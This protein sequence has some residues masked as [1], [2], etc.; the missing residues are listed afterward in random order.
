MSALRYEKRKIDNKKN[1]N[2]IEKE[3]IGKK[4]RVTGYIPTTKQ[5]NNPLYNT[6]TGF[7]TNNKMYYLSLKEIIRVTDKDDLEVYKKAQSSIKDKK[8]EIDMGLMKVK[9]TNFKGLE[10]GGLRKTLGR[11]TLP[12]YVPDSIK[13]DY[14]KA[15]K[16]ADNI[17]Q[18]RIRNSRSKER[19]FSSDSS[20]FHNQNIERKNE[21]S[22]TKKHLDYKNDNTNAKSRTVQNTPNKSPNI[23]LNYRTSKFSKYN[24]KSNEEGGVDNKNNG[25]SN[26][27]DEDNLYKNSPNVGLR[28]REYN[29]NYFNK[30][31]ISDNKQKEEN[32]SIKELKE[33]N[34]KTTLNKEKKE[35]NFQTDKPKKGDEKI[36]ENEIKVRKRERFQIKKEESPK[37]IAD[38]GKKEKQ[39]RPRSFFREGRTFQ[40]SQTA[41][42]FPTKIIQGVKNEIKNKTLQ[43]N[44]NEKSNERRKKFAQ[45][46]KEEKIEFQTINEQNIKSRNALK[47][48]KKENSDV[49]NINGSR[50]YH[51]NIISQLPNNKQQNK[52]IDK[53]IDN[54]LNND[55]TLEEIKVN[56]RVSNIRERIK[57]NFNNLKM[58]S[59]LKNIIFNNPE[60]KY[61]VLSKTQNENIEKND[62]KRATT[63][64]E[65][66]TNEA[67]FK[68]KKDKTNSVNKETEKITVNLSLSPKKRFHRTNKSENYH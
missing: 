8:D 17:Y 14:V 35:N 66:K 18:R 45:E 41:N 48:N 4:N 26:E 19:M 15:E 57:N 50:R 55:K 39:F 53:Q 27:K 62:T 49:S 21:I 47:V 2:T 7:N 37:N 31:K 43:T 3:V 6:M 61:I 59:D 40:K 58:K 68:L 16:A 44:E 28:N 56:K 63:D 36:L 24:N 64:E 67:K 9:R 29:Y 54:S 46:K 33:E 5:N 22:E 20:A 23:T 12:R 1:E 38:D 13:I 30:S 52:T 10:I 42:E 25:V 34:R 65:K 11:T 32:K 51:K 60:K